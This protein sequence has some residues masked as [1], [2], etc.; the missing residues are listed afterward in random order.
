MPLNVQNTI[1]LVASVITIF[2]GV[3]TTVG[4]LVR[5]RT[6]NT[7]PTPPIAAPAARRS[8]PTWPP[9]APQPT[10]PP[11][12]AAR[13]PRH[14]VIFGFSL[15]GLIAVT[16]YSV[17]LLANYIASGGVSTGVPDGSP[18]I[19]GNAALFA[20]T[21]TCVIVAC[22]GVMVSAFRIERWGWVAGASIA[23]A[24]SLLTIGIFAIVALIPTL[25]Y[26]LSG[27]TEISARPK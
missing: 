22:G 8:S 16:L 3:M 23:L 24:V 13:G 20:I 6:R 26:G 7:S 5:W 1:N 9:P 25:I 12:P 11:A 18:L 2:G 10:T 21:L 14:R 15:A 27:P 17:E 4:A 19:G